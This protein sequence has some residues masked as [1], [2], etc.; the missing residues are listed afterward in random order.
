MLP[1]LI[2]SDRGTPRFWYSLATLTTKRRLASTSRFRAASSP[3]L[4]RRARSTSWALD[5]GCDWA[6][7]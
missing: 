3:A 4:I 7:S 1:E 5:R 6:I 2:R